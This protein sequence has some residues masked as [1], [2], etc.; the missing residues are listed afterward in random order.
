MRVLFLGNSFTY[1]HDLPV[2]AARL[3]G[4]DTDSV[5]RGGAYL[6]QFLDPKDELNARMEAALEKG[7]WDYV[8]L[9]E[10][11]FNAVGNPEDFLK[12]VKGLCEKIRAL[13]AAPVLYCSWA[14]K[15][16]G[17]FLQEAGLSYQ[18]MME[19]LLASYTR[20]AQENQALIAPVGPAFAQLQKDYPLYDPDTLH[21]SLYGSFLAA[22]VICQTISPKV[23]FS[24]WIPEGMEQAAADTFQRKAKED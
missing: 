4:W 9:Q 7:P 6:H 17:P 8:V 11:S 10:Q 19:G 21:P 13:G 14:Y 18:Q 23:S 5:T 15:E 22:C 16:G 2:M 12:S 24:S 3:T 1:F 20:A